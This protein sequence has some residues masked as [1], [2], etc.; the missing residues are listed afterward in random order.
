MEGQLKRKEIKKKIF[1]AF[2]YNHKAYQHLQMK[3]TNLLKSYQDYKQKPSIQAKPLL[4]T[5]QQN[6]E[7]PDKSLAYFPSQ[8]PKHLPFL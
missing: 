3:T 7:H 1:Y 5:T 2:C 8:R 6:K 4:V